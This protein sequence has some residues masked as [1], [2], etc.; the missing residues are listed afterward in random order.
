MSSMGDTTGRAPRKTQKV[1]HEVQRVAR[2]FCA[3]VPGAIYPM[4]SVPRAAAAAF[5]CAVSTS[6]VFVLFVFCRPGPLF[7]LYPI[8]LSPFLGRI[9]VNG[10]VKET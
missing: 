10:T 8:S 3:A 1:L 2:A 9:G 7:S 5:P 4:A 6:S